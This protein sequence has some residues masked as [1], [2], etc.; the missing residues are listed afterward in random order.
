MGEAGRRP[1]REKRRRA[2]GELEGEVLAALWGAGVP[3]TA[4]QV[5]E[6]LPGELAH[7]TV[8][9]IL[10]RLFDKGVLTRER[11]GRGYAYAPVDDQAGH[12]A[13]QMRSLLDGGADRA[14]VL[15]RFVS[16]LPSQD[17]ELLLQ[18]LAEQRRD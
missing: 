6:Q 18:L 10:V 3:L 15:A 16:E 5:N 7:T 9:T 14:A 17:E 2:A 8:L 4:A 12:T 11:A 13:D 1:T